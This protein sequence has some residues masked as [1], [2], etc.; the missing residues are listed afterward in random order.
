LLGQISTYGRITTKPTP[1]AY[2]NSTWCGRLGGF[3]AF[4]GTLEWCAGAP[5]CRGGVKFYLDLHGQLGDFG[6]LKLLGDAS[7][8]DEQLRLYA[9]AEIYFDWSKAIDGM[10]DAVV[11]VIAGTS[12]PE[13]S[14][15]AKI[16]KLVMLPVK[17]A[18]G[19][20]RGGKVVVDAP[21]GGVQLCL[22]LGFLEWERQFCF[23]PLGAIGRRL[24]Q[25]EAENV[26]DWPTTAR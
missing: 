22:T 12:D 5:E 26:V 25:M 24:L 4:S 3:L 2:L 17:A 18:L 11:G 7:Y 6:K 9:E 15:V 16:L 21:D 23:P 1:Q 10:V 13:S 14:P 20:V 19:F 8:V